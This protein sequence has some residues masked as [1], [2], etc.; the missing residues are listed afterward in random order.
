MGRTEPMDSH[1]QTVAYTP[2]T[3]K[4]QRCSPCLS[5]PETLRGS[6]GSLDE[7]IPLTYTQKG[8]RICSLLSSD[9]TDYGNDY[10]KGAYESVTAYPEEWHHVA[11][12]SPLYHGLGN[13]K[14]SLPPLKMVR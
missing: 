1:R 10:S 5:T 4:Q 6:S 3:R 12:R 14:P 13:Q 8:I 11:L 7:R 2:R 9:Q